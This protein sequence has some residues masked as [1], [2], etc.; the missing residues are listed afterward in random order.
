MNYN[1]VE[2]TVRAVAAELGFSRWQNIFS[3]QNKES[4]YARFLC[5]QILSN[6]PL[7]SATLAAQVLGIEPKC[8]KSFIAK[9]YDAKRYGIANEKHEACVSKILQ[10]INAPFGG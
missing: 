2:K 8:L 10:Q 3:E 1:E 6:R 4:D 7:F 5:G 9:P